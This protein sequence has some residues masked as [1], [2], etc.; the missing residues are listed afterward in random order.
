MTCF[1][2]SA[3]EITPGLKD[4]ARI[5]TIVESVGVYADRGNFE[6][7]EHLYDDEVL[8]DY[9]SL[10]G[11]AA[12]LK[13]AQGLIT[14]WASVLPGFD[15][16]HHGI[17]NIRVELFTDQAIA[18]ADVVADHYIGDLFWQVSGSYCYQMTRRE[19]N[20]KITG[21]SFAL[22]GETGTREVF[23]P[24]LERANDSP[25]AYLQRRRTADAVTSFLKAL[26]QKDM[27]GFAELWHD[28]AVQ[29]MPFA[30][31]GF[32]RRVVGKENLLKHYSGWP[33]NS[34]EAD[35]TSEL[36]FYPMQDPNMVFAEWKG[37]V[38]IVPTKR[39]Y[40]QHYG[41]LFHVENGQITLFREY[42][43]PA[44]FRYA[45]GLDEGVAFKKED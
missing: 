33:E 14:E 38:D 45:F 22:T 12:E 35:F 41:G 32:P 4:K 26:E 11:Q 44:P 36:R 18:T 20:W 40:L 15:L 2:V 34:G 39:K 29:E 23:T 5:A 6:A 30:P 27:Q 37:D 24:A 42:F 9:S 13:S 19:S 16:T 1:S 8:V 43:D 25:V 28:N 10:N 31:D 7:L 3:G 17:T 21:H